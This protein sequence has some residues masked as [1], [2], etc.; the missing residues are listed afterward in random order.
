MK[1]TILTVFAA[2]CAFTASA[3]FSE[4]NKPT[5]GIKAGVNFASVSVTQQ[6]SSAN[7]GSGTLTSFSAGAF[8]DLPIGTNFSIQPG[9]Y[10]SGKGYNVKA[11]FNLG[12]DFNVSAEETVK[13]SYI[14][15]PLPLLYNASNSAGKFFFGAGPYAAAAIKAKGKASGVIDIDLGEEQMSGSDEDEQ[16]L[17]IGKNGDV[18]RLDYGVTGLVGFRLNNGLLISANYDLGLAN[19]YNTDDTQKMKT[20]TIGVSLGFSF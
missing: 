3:Q 7:Y 12:E 14:Q 18:K 9:L 6:G 5:F 2:V 20:R 17:T 16:D 8:A 10:Y 4:P 1:K 15:L 19:I 11:N 13:L